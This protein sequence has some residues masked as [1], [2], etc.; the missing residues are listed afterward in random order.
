MTT[1]TKIDKTF[2]CLEYKRRQR[3]N[4]F[5]EIKDLTHD[6][7]RAYFEERAERGPLGDWWKRV[8]AADR[9]GPS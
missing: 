3:T 7:E 9:Q 2:D 8:K 4:V 6:Q 1:P 5:E